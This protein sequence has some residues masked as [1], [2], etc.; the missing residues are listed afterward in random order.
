MSERKRSRRR[1]SKK[2]S[3][4]KFVRFFQENLKYLIGAALLLVIL[5]ALIVA[6][7]VEGSSGP[8]LCQ[9]GADYGV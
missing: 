4:N 5:I 3:N 1:K 6:I 7:F 8:L 2:L 9:M